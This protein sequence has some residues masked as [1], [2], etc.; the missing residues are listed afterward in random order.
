MP[1]FNRNIG[2][3]VVPL[4]LQGSRILGLRIRDCVQLRTAVLYIHRGFV[5]SFCSYKGYIYCLVKTK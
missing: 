5:T 2:V 3:M 4:V 1:F